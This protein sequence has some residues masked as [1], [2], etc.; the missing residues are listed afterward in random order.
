MPPIP[1]DGEI[2]CRVMWR[3][4]GA[5]V[6]RF[7]SRRS[8]WVIEDVSQRARLVANV[9]QA[10]LFAHFFCALHILRFTTTFRTDCL[11]I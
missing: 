4:I 3:D 8:L 10:E 6:V 2:C 11:P 7:A 9:G 1:P 5:V